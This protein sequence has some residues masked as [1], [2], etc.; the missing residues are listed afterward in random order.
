MNIINEKPCSVT[1][2][3]HSS[4]SKIAEFDNVIN[5]NM[6]T[7]QNIDYAYDS[8]EHKMIRFTGKIDKTLTIDVDKPIDK[9][10]LYK[11]V[12]VDLSG[13]PDA[14]NVHVIKCVP[15][16]RHKKK[17]IN[18]KWNKKYGIKYRS[19]TVTVKGWKLKSYQDGT[20]EFVK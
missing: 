12:G 10:E 2:F 8:A 7:E 14:Y 19:A 18:K 17:R 9:N 5:A 13:I 15:I 4:G 16:R 1:F 11:T 3:S 6:H 20:F